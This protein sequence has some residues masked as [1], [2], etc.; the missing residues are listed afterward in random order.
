M[1]HPEFQQKYTMLKISIA[2]YWLSIGTSVA[3]V[4]GIPSLKVVYI[5]IVIEFRRIIDI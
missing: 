3:K 1:Q 5:L 2:E 4:L